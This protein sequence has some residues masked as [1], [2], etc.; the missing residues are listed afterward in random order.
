MLLDGVDIGG[1]KLKFLRMIP[2]DPMTGGTD[3]G[4]R[5]VQDDPD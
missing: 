2:I 3:W 5:A 4:L 1:K